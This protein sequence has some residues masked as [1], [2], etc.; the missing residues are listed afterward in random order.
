MLDFRGADAI[1]ERAERAMRRG[2]AV[3]AH[4]RGA[5]QR[6][7]LLRSDDVDDALALVE[8][9][10]IFEPEIARILRQHRDLLGAFR[11]GIGQFAIGGRHVV[12]DHGER[13]VRRAHLASRIAQA[14][15]GLRR[16][17]LMHEM[18]VDIEQAGAVG[19]LVDQMVVPD[20][21]VERARFHGLN[22]DCVEWIGCRVIGA[23]RAQV[24][25][26]RRD[27]RPAWIDAV[28]PA[29]KAPGQAIVIPQDEGECP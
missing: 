27:Q 1:G 28:M 9:V 18:P 22:L 13:L 23:G 12:V 7:A 3:A 6:E 2:V 14:L 16:R 8:L 20:L 25:R 10:V 21:V 29:E 24:A 11:I 26:S 19:L 4:D 5:R 17:H 15:E